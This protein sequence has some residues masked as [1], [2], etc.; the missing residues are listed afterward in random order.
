MGAGDL[1]QQKPEVYW[2]LDLLK[3]KPTYRKAGFHDSQVDGLQAI[4]IKG[5]STAPGDKTIKGNK[6]NPLSTKISAEF[7]AY[8]GFPG[9]PVPP[10]G[11]PG[12]VMIHGGGG[13]AY[14]KYAKKMDR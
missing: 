13:T 5:Y 6:P 14:P 2:D 7:F 4:M 9:K 3:V 10:G 8:M 11:F 1:R 12:V